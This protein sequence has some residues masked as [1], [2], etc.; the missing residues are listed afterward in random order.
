MTVD[1]DLRL[2]AA[3]A[4][5]RDMGRYARRKFLDRG[6]FSVGLKGPQDYLTEVDSE[7]ERRIFARLTS[8]FPDDGFVGEEGASR[9]AAAG[10]PT[11]VIDPIDGTSNFA[12]GVPRFCVSLAAVIGSQAVIGVIYDPSVDE[13]FY[14]R[15]GGGAWLDGE[16]MRVSA[17]TDLATA[18]V[19]VGWNVRAG[20]DKYLGL[21]SRIARTGASPT[22]GGSGALGLAYVAAGRYDGYVETH[23]KAWDCLAAICMIEEAGG[24]VSDF[25][26]GD[27]L[28]Q[29]N[30]I[31]AAAPGVKEELVRVAG[32]L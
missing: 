21:L 32:V 15:R 8:L 23:M 28:T 17:T 29:G 18:T 3:K 20:V 2:D 11:W 6:S 10:A 13:L 31:V 14:A 12:H 22:R 26:T 4:L 27:A 1:L 25:L 24:W 16:P 30:S 7:V 5:A 19:E 9:P